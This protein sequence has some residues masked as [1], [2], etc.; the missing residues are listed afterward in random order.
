MSDAACSKCGANN[1]RWV[2]LRRHV[3]V[4]VFQ[5]QNC[6]HPEIEEDWHAPLTPLV[7]GN[8]MNCGDRRETDTCSNCGLNR[9]EDM[10]VHDE[11]RQMVAPTHNMLNAARTASNLGRRL[12]ALKLATAAAY[13]NEEAQ[14]DRARALRIWLLSAIGEPKCA[15]DDARAW[16]EQEPDPSALAW[17]SLGQQQKHGGFVGAAAESFHKALKKD[18]SQHM[19]RAERSRLLM[20]MH[21]EGQAA[22]DACI[23]L[24]SDNEKAVDLALEVAELLC[25][26]FEAGL[27]DDEVARILERAGQN[28]ERSPSLLAHRARLAA[29]EGDAVSAKRDL[30]KARK[31]NE[32]LPI[33]DR[34]DRLLKPQRSSWWK[35]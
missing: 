10:Q 35:W 27:R 25:E 9:E 28:A 2:T 29:I 31:L 18:A 6:G 11:L 1:L 30:K 23:V 19:I 20:E 8:C 5:C 21:R 34:V 32:N 12:V 17:A 13:L 33:Y 15:L 4:D 3:P 26:K 7:P 24:E 16:V 22:E 14:G